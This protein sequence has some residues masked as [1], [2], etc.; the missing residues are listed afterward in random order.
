MIINLN[1]IQENNHPMSS[2]VSIDL[3][4]VDHTESKS[5]E[6][7]LHF[8]PS[9]IASYLEKGLLRERAITSLLRDSLNTEL[10]MHIYDRQNID[11]EDL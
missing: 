11:N 9:A 3:H 10:G 6:H 4:I 7:S 5:Y 2:G 1:M 8:P